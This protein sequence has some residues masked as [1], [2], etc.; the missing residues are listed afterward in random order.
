MLHLTHAKS[1]AE[2]VGPAFHEIGIRVVEATR[3]E[4][5]ARRAELV[6]KRAHRRDHLLGRPTFRAALDRLLDEWLHREAPA[7]GR[8]RDARDGGHHLGGDPAVQPRRHVR[9]LRGEV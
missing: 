5:T 3:T 4:R 7:G 2:R 9:L 8:S 6:G 1:G